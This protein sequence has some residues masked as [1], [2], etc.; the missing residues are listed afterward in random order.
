MHLS[1]LLKPI[2][3]LAFIATLGT[4][5][6]LLSA[7]GGGGGSTTPSGNTPVPVT[8]TFAVGGTVSGLAQGGTLSLGNGVDT[9]TVTGNGSFSFPSKL[10]SG[11]SFKV[12][13][14]N[15]PGSACTLTNDAG[16]IAA[17]DVSSVAVSCRPF[18][19][20]GAESPFQSLN[21]MATDT[22]GNIFVADAISQLILKIT[23]TGVISTFAGSRGLAGSADGVATAA[24]FNL[25]GNSGIVFDRDG[26]L[27][28]A[29][30][31]NGK[32]RKIT[33]TGMVSTLAGMAGNYCT[34]FGDR[35]I[36]R[37]GA[38]GTAIF[39]SLGKIK[40]DTNGDLLVG[41]GISAIRRVTTSGVVTSVSFVFDRN[42]P[43]ANQLNATI[44]FTP[45]ANGDLFVI[46][47]SRR[48]LQVTGGVVSLFAGANPISGEPRNGARLTATFVNPRA[49]ERDAMGN[50]FIAD[51]SSLRKI[52]SDGV[53]ST[54]AGSAL[55][56]GSADGTGSAA[57]F[58]SLRTLALAA[59]GN[60]LAGDSNDR[61]IRTVT[62]T[63][64][65]STLAATPL[66]RDY[67]DG[68]AAAAR[69]NPGDQLATDPNG[70]IYVVDT[71]QHVIR[72]ITPDGVVSLYAGTLGVRG[73]ANGNRASASFNAPTGLVGDA[74]GNL[75]TVDMVGSD[76]RSLLLQIRKISAAG[77]VT[78]LLELGADIQSAISLAVDANGNLAFTTSIGGVVYRVSA[79]GV[80]SVL[81]T[82][83]RVEQLLN[84]SDNS[85]VPQGIVFDA[86]GNLYVS[87][88]G[89]LVV[90][91]LN[92]A[93]VLSLFAGTSGVRGI[94]DGPVGTASFNFSDLDYLAAD[95]VGNVFLSGQ[96][97]LRKISPAGVTSTPVLSWGNP[98]LGGLVVSKGILYGMTR[99]AVL[100]VGL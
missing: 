50:L 59:N 24:S 22:A 52:T 57:K 12:T 92:P 48:I 2:K 4:I 73:N 83:D 93:G 43:T 85:F 86:S 9:L 62:P 13:L 56:T 32:I 78:T 7:C 81:F 47:S 36:P 60:I 72:K 18:L 29:D 74:Q 25:S 71:Q 34:V 96:G 66:V 100:Q 27:L 33:S 98:A 6:S 23:P 8:R 53:V 97:R 11:A 15:S 46:N 67:R 70:N 76:P 5:A 69:F 75:Y 44:D 38:G 16:V 1:P 14:N 30:T 54:L 28:V 68:I 26:N 19:L 95:A 61:I 20:A 45:G 82:K 65:V 77:V 49:I 39:E 3:S 37:D 42:A 87:D 35:P 91:K 63:G 89:Y 41:D 31:C 58:V 55:N 99:Y 80:L 51:A 64:V 94:A 17:S 79:A 88:T 40:L 90:Y 84:R 10:A 21:G